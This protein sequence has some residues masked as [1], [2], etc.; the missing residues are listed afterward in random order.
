MQHIVIIGNGIAGV[1]A[2]RHIRRLSSIHKVTI[3]SAESEY[4]FSRTALM[5]VYMGHMKFEHTQPYEN[6]FWRK[7]KIDLVHDTVLSINVQ[8]KQLILQK[9]PL[10]S[11]D[12]LIIATGSKTS[13]YDW[14]GQ[15]AEGVLGLY[16]KQDLEQLEKLSAGAKQA[17]VVG[18]GLIGIELAEMLHSRGMQ[19]HMLVREKSF[20]N[21]VLPAGESAM[22]NREILR[23]G[24]H[25]HLGEELDSIVHTGGK[26]NAVQTKSGKKIDA[27]IIGICT[28][29]K[30]N[31]G[32]IANSGIATDKGILVDG[33]LQTNVPGIY[34]IGDC[35][36]QK[37]ALPGRKPIEAVWYTGRMMGEALAA[38][39]CGKST[40]YAPGP[41]FNSAKFFNIE[42]MTYGQVQASEKEG[43][44]EH[45]YWEHAD[46]TRSLRLAYHPGSRKFLGINLMGIR[47]KHDFFHQAL[48]QE[49]S[50]DEIVQNLRKANF[51]PEFYNK[52][53]GA[54]IESFSKKL[55]PNT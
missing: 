2:A 9:Q 31:I 51:D 8:A 46:G 17:V 26:A 13:M 47:M 21:T 40:A 42:Y 3:V 41:W 27:Q 19:V 48:V 55:Q 32:F 25:L 5:Y 18:G 34:A 50:V 38:T 39:I 7:S 4:F 14:S 12:S 20:W 23:H 6:S 52:Y 22:V 49:K 29:V 15:E 36:Q 1:T 53:E 43:E 11:Y 35:A 37:N 54:I 30:P 16:S 33:N 44:E 10:L 28:G 45:F 24:I